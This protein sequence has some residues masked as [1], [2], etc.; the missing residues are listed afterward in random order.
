M[1]GDT[2]LKEVHRDHEK[3][4]L[5]IRSDYDAFHV[6][7]RPTRDAHPL[8]FPEIR[9]GKDREVGVEELLNRRDF[10]IWDGVESVPA[11][12]E[13]AHQPARLV[14]LE[15]ARLVHHVAQEEVSPKERD[16]RETS[17]SATSAPRLDGGEE[18]VKALCRELVIA[19]LL[20]IAAGPKDTPGRG[21]RFRNEF[22]QGFAPFGLHPFL[23]VRDQPLTTYLRRAAGESGHAA[24]SPSVSP[25]DLTSVVRGGLSPACA[26]PK[27]ATLP[28]ASVS[29]GGSP[30]DIRVAPRDVA[31]VAVENQAHNL[32]RLRDVQRFFEKLTGRPVSRHHDEEAIH[33]FAENATVGNRHEW[34]GVDDD[35]VISPAS[36]PPELP[37]PGRLPH[38]L[39]G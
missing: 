25:C 24:A 19:E 31:I 20:T 29:V 17:D 14:R 38:L 22:W 6:G 16:A 1:D 3:A 15:I 18:H 30:R 10:R 8:A 5:G 35:V 37:Q 9:V 32:G 4:L 7:E 11:L 34:R 27:K 23:R 12:P 2:A 21:H 39:G 33:P 36:L 26:A 28:S 13:N